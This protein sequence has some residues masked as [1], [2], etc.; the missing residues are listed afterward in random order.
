MLEMQSCFPGFGVSLEEKTAAAI[1]LLQEQEREALK[2]SPNGFYLA[3]SGGK[4]SLT[5]LLLVKDVVE[6]LKVLFVD[7]GL[8]FPETVE[9]TEVVVPIDLVFQNN[10]CNKRHC[11]SQQRRVSYPLTVVREYGVCA[12][13]ER[14]F[15]VDK[16]AGLN[17]EYDCG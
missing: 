1:K 5:T 6:D 3:F 17:A 14:A 12:E 4:D 15:S 11:N 13:V 9:H 7:T 2:L 8:E 10:H 16:I